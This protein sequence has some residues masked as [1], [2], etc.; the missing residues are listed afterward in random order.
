MVAT[1]NK[2]LVVDP[3]FGHM[4]VPDYPLSGKN[5]RKISE[6]ETTMT[7]EVS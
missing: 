1:V 4:W 5:W 2:I 7:I 3:E 6:T